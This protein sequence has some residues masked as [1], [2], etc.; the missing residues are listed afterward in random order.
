MFLYF[1][2]LISQTEREWLIGNAKLSKG[3]ERKVKSYIKK[4]LQNFQTIELPLLIKKGFSF[5]I[6]LLLNIVTVLQ[7][8]VTPKVKAILLM[9]I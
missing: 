8:V 1:K 3:Y 6:T 7:L 9:L 4:K 5:L 2:I